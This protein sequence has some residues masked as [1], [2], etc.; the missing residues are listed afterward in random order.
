MSS[1]LILSYKAYQRS[2]AS[3]SGE[4]CAA[5]DS[6]RDSALE[7]NPAYVDVVVH[8]WQLFTGRVAR[9]P[10]ASKQSVSRGISPSCI[11]RPAVA[12]GGAGPATALRCLAGG[13]TA[14]LT[15]QRR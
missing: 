13:R 6:N 15:A 7:L 9:H 4:V 2:P 12:A 11:E 8:R 5:Y 1:R 14:N 10:L 3:A